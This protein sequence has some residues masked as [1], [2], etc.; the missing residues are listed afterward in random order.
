MSTPTNKDKLIHLRVIL[1]SGAEFTTV[2]KNYSVKWSTL[3]TSLTSFHTE[4]CV[5]NFPVFVDLNEVAAIVRVFSNEE[6]G[7]SSE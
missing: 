5:E 2:V 4:G 7:E 3:D 6:R 1:K